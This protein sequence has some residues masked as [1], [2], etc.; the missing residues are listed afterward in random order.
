MSPLLCQLYLGHIERTKFPDILADQ[1]SLLLR[2]MDDPLLLTYNVELA[3]RYL[4]TMLHVD[5]A[6]NCKVNIEKC[7]ISFDATTPAG[8]KIKKLQTDDTWIPWIS[9][10]INRVTLEVKYDYSRT[11]GTV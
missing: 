9:L 4:E 7:L 10:L 8:E 6:D 5:P 1:D 2:L 11:Q 3:K